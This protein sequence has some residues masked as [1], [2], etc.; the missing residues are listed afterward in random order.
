VKA[1]VAG[2]AALIAALVGSAG[3][4]P[5]AG[6]HSLRTCPANHYE[7]A[8][9]GLVCATPRLADRAKDR[10]AVR[11][12]GTRWLCHR[13]VATAPALGSREHPYPLGT[14]AS[15]AGGRWSVRIDAVDPDATERILAVEPLDDPPAVGR[16]FFLVHVTA[17]FNGPGTAVA[18]EDLLSG[19]AAVGPSQLAYDQTDANSCGTVPDDL[20]DVGDVFAGA[21]VAGN[22]CFA[23]RSA[24][25][26]GLLLYWLDAATQQPSAW[27]AVR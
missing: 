15:V 25:A 24:D 4:A 2:A 5:A 10:L 20:Q 9:K 13:A 6:C 27:F 19:L 14:P 18:W 7:Y 22:V 3:R 1:V 12:H 16:Q 23:V 26:Q 17:T 21:T 8:W 11:W